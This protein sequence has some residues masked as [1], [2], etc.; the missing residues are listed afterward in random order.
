MKCTKCMKGKFSSHESR[1]F[2]NE[3]KKYVKS[4]SNQMNKNLSALKSTQVHLFGT[5]ILVNEV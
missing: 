3:M 2:V 4:L 1:F 5:R